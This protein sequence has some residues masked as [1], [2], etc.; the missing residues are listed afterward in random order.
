M[1]IDLLNKIKMQLGKDVIIWN[2]HTQWEE[3]EKLYYTMLMD[4]FKK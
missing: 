3:N 1:Y 2:Y 4:R